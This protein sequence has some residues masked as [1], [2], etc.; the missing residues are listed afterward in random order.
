[1]S[2]LHTHKV[3]IL[4]TVNQENKIQFIYSEGSEY[5]GKV[6]KTLSQMVEDGKLTNENAEAI[7]SL[8]KLTSDAYKDAS[9]FDAESDEFS[10]MV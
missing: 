10:D 4:N 3:T 5:K 1:M 2:E 9:L 7:H 8:I 6:T